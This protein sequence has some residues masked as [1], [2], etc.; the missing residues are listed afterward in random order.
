[1]N[2]TGIKKIKAGQPDHAHQLAGKELAA[3]II[4]SLPG[5]FYLFDTK[6]NILTWNKNFELISGYSHAEILKIRPIDFFEG[7]GQ[8]LVKQNFDR[9]IKEGEASFEANFLTKTGEKIPYYFTGKL[10]WYNG[11]PCVLGTGIDVSEKMR[12]DEALGEYAYRME[13]I[14]RATKEALW[15]WNLVS[16]KLWGNEIHQQLYGLQWNDPVPDNN[17][18]MERIHPEDRDRIK[19]INAVRLISSRNIFISEYRF[20]NG[21]G[22]YRHIY[23]RCFILRDKKN[24]PVSMMGSMMDITEQ[25]NAEAALLASEERY[26]YLFYN[27]PACIIIWDS[28][29]H[30]IIEVNEAAVNVYGYPAKGFLKLSVVDLVPKKEKTRFL[31]IAAMAKRDGFDKKAV[32]ILQ[33]TRK[34]AEII[35]DVSFR[36][37]DYNGR[38]A[39]LSMCKNVTE[40]L[41]LEKKHANEKLLHQQQITDAVIT[42]QEKERSELGEELHDNI[43]QILATA[44]LYLECILTEKELRR[45][46]ILES[47]TMLEKAMLEI[48]TLSKT[49]LPPSL[50]EIGLIDALEGLIE[51][52]RE[53]YSFKIK[54]KWSNFNESAL[55]EKLKLTIFRI[56]Q[57]QL[58]NIHKHSRAK[59]AWI[60]LK[61]TGK[62]FHLEIKDDGIGFNT[63]SKRNGVGI[64]NII[65]RAEVNNGKVVLDSAPAKGCVL[66]V[67]FVV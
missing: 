32:T 3:S 61:K 36:K 10:S 44:R 65:S 22:Q 20:R 26:K 8:K 21:N 9:V 43:N 27:N 34:G 62:M 40:K 6:R 48:R 31:K 33:K 42:G 18:R 55:N 54:G 52:G 59:T 15:E 66:S 5:I 35:M 64:R 30:H 56:V 13:L 14:S 19:K 16:G 11:K 51:N 37:I 50:G 17:T 1:M 53:L 60:S 28:D 25:K 57:E 4:N 24:H 7:I 67:E 29:D 58:N 46:L 41:L 39:I 2:K 38:P 63:S 49:L 47:K 45:D 12:M 23:D